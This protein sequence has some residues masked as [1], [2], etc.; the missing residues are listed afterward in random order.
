MEINSVAN[1]SKDYGEMKANTEK[2]KHAEQE[3]GTYL[4]LLAA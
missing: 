3:S 4:I 1:V 2:D